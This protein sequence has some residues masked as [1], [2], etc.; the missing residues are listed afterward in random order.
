MHSMIRK[1]VFRFIHKTIV[2]VDSITIPVFDS[3]KK[4]AARIVNLKIVNLR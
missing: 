4:A 1:M 2:I 3:V